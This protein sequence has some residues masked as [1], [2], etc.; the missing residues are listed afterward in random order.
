MATYIYT[1]IPQQE[2][3]EPEQFEIQQSM[4]DP[5]LTVHPVDGRPVKRVITGGIGFIKAGGG[6][7]TSSAGG[8]CGSH[9]GCH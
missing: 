6:T 8:S 5:A 7:D 2:G 1:T 9:C 4:R 3:E